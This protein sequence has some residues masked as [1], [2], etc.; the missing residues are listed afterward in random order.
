MA[1]NNTKYLEFTGYISRGDFI[2]IS[3]VLYLVHR[4]LLFVM[5]SNTVTNVAFVTPLCYIILVLVGYSRFCTFAKRI[6]DI[7]GEK[8]RNGFHM[9][10]A[11]FMALSSFGLNNQIML[12][13]WL[14]VFAYCALIPGKYS[15]E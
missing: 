13:V 12:W 8:E 1:D 10:A 4:Y 9:L 15:K 3:L 14:A 6:L 7:T 11:V 5:D 2:W